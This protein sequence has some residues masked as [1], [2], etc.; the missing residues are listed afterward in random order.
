MARAHEARALVE[1]EVEEMNRRP[2][3]RHNTNTTDTTTRKLKVESDASP[4]IPFF[5]NRQFLVLKRDLDSHLLFEHRRFLA[6]K[7]DLE[8]NLHF[9]NLPFSA[10][11]GSSRSQLCSTD[12]VASNRPSD[13][14]I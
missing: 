12:F 2:I 11:G 3:D 6:L 1:S 13:L 4:P 8:A 14:I 5:E 10:R 9:E 7:R